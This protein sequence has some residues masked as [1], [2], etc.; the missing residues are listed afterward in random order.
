MNSTQSAKTTELLQLDVR[1][2]E[3]CPIK[4]LIALVDAYVRFI[5]TYDMDPFGDCELRDLYYLPALRRDEWY[6]CVVVSVFDNF[7]TT[8]MREVAINLALFRSECVNT[9]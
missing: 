5:E 7:T 3:Q 1:N 8:P 6:R 2:H 4:L 9:V